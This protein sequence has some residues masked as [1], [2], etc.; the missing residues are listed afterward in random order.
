M[1]K[2]IFKHKIL[3]FFLLVGIYVTTV[4]CLEF[5]SSLSYMR[6]GEYFFKILNRGSEYTE[7]EVV[8]TPSGSKEEKN[9]ILKINEEEMIYQDMKYSYTYVDKE[10]KNGYRY[11]LE[12]DYG[13]NVIF[14]DGKTYCWNKED[15]GNN[16][17]FVYEEYELELEPER[18]K[19]SLEILSGKE[20]DIDAEDLGLDHTKIF[21]KE[22]LEKPEEKYHP[23]LVK[24]FLIS[25]QQYCEKIEERN[26]RESKELVQVFFLSWIVVSLAIAAGEIIVGLELKLK[27]FWYEVKPHTEQLYYNL[28][29]IIMVITLVILYC[30]LLEVYF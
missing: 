27:S 13:Y 26:A 7:C 22:K 8:V 20:I 2:K 25:Y 21:Y 9:Q 23:N 6:S 15:K 14:P 17:F 11:Y 30:K 3:L 29:Y 12:S 24:A 28:Y 19:K 10:H 1:G 16:V 4:L 5:I 18:I